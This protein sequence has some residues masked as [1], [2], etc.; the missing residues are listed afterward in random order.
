MSAER[1][2]LIGAF[3]RHRF[4]LKLTSKDVPL[5]ALLVYPQYPDTF[6]SYKYVL[7]FISKKTAFPPLGLLTVASLLPS[8][9]E[10]KL[11]DLNVAPLED[12]QIAWADVV[13][14]GAMLIQRPSAQEIINRCKAQ[15]KKVV[16]GGPTSSSPEGYQQVDHFVQGE[17]EVTLPLFLEDLERGQLQHIYS[18]T[19]RP[20]ISQTPLPDWSLINF[21]DYASLAV[22]YS[23]GCPYDCEFCDIILMYGRIPRTKSPAQMVKE[24][25]VLYEAG[26]RGDVFV[27][28]DNFIGNKTKV[29]Q[30]LTQLIRWQKEHKYPFKLMTEASTNLADDEELMQMMSAANFHKV[31]LGIETPNLDSLKECKKIQNTTRNLEEAVGIIHRNGMQVMGGFIV[32]FDHDTENIFDAQIAFIQKV[33]IVTA[34]VGMLSAIPQTRLWHRLKAEG[35]LLQEPTGE[36]TDGSLNFVPRMGGRKLIE[37]YQHL[38]KTIY[39]PRN[40]YKRINTFIKNYQPTVKDKVTREGL[41]ATL[42]SMWHIGVLSRARLFYWKLIIKTSIRRI[43]V[44][45]NA[46]EFAVYGL[47][48]K[49][50]SDKVLRLDP[51]EYIETTNVPVTSTEKSTQLV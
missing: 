36:N 8:D 37:G 7:R 34:M 38:L 41:Y 31:F 15:G 10:K 29:K 16:L 47:H 9:W 21:K 3:S 22:Q 1:T 43:R 50:V 24:F 27:V 33:G 40:Y 48:Y 4:F 46:I 45:P 25:Q 13:F 28:D 12:E 44:L 30:M 23:R 35:R 32:G 2:W 49:K 51:G 18:T 26:W 11:V 6:W 5:K 14:I 39:S 17:A 42:K 19:T 20:D